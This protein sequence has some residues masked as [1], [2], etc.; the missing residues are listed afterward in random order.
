MFSSRKVVEG[1]WL[2]E[3]FY[4]S[5]VSCWFSSKTKLFPGRLGP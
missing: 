5:S 2:A 3:R 1:L 4:A